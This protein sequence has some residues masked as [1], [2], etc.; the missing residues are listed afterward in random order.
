MRVVVTPLMDKGI[1]RKIK[2]APPSAEMRSAWDEQHRPVLQL[3]YPDEAASP[4]LQHL[5]H[6]QISE[7]RERVLVLHGYE[8]T[9]AGQLF[10]QAWQ[11]EPWKR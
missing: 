2:A 1:A 11:V 10:A 8:R 5:I 7:A 3:W 9:S 6:P 4:M